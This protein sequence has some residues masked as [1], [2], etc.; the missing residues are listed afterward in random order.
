MILSYIEMYEENSNSVFKTVLPPPA[1][2]FSWRFTYASKADFVPCPSLETALKSDD[3]NERN[4][5]KRRSYR[6]I[7][8][9]SMNDD[10]NNK[11]F[12]HDNMLWQTHNKFMPSI[13]V[14]TT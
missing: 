11:L 14:L 4:E 6:F 7:F 5:W 13:I 8:V 9:K 10:Y 3:F 2:K 1:F 12:S